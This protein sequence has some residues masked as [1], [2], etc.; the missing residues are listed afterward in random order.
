MLDSSALTIFHVH[1]KAC[2]GMSLYKKKTASEMHEAN[3]LD[4]P[5]HASDDAPDMPQIIS[6]PDMPKMMLQTCPQTIRNA[7][8]VPQMMPQTCPR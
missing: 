3:I 6:G 2:L 5:R 8:D 7:P 1:I 4:S